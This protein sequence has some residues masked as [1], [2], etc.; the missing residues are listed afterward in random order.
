MHSLLLHSAR[1]DKE[2]AIMG[3]ANYA[4]TNRSIQSAHVIFVV[5][6]FT[7]F[8]SFHFFLQIKLKK[9]VFRSINKRS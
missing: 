4:S 8:F 1:S 2:I 5:Y 7:D 6:I 3:R 9:K